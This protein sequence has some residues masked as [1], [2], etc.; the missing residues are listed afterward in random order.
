MNFSDIYGAYQNKIARKNGNTYDVDILIFSLT[1]H[2]SESFEKIISE[3]INVENFF[4][5]PIQWN[6]NSNNIVGTI[7]GYKIEEIEDETMRRNECLIKSLMS[8]QNEKVW[9]KF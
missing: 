4:K 9:K 7:C 5:N 6:E 8:W 3:K 1:G 2:D